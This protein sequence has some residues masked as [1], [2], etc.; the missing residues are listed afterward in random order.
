MTVCFCIDDGMGISFNS[1]R[2]S[3][4]KELIARL[5]AQADG[6]RI[7]IKEYSAR[8]FEGTGAD[9]CVCGGFECAGENDL[10]FV[11]CEDPT[12]YME[13]AERVIIYHWNRS[14]P[15]DTVLTATP[16]KL[17]FELC[18]TYDFEGSSHERITE[19]IWKK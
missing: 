4:D 2:Q 7:L 18:G 14:Y 9:A 15:S 12:R 5:S 1:R 16:D 3:K 6:K 19:E 8:L 11:E 10:V 13:R 17:G